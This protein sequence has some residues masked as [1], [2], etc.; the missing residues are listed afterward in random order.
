ML[1]R[2]LALFWLAISTMAGLVQAAEPLDPEKAYKFSARALD[3]KTI[4]ARWD[5][6][7][8]YYMYREKIAF[9]ADEAQLGTPDVAARVTSQ[10]K[11]KVIAPTTSVVITVSQCTVQKPPPSPYSPPGGGPPSATIRRWRKKC[12]SRSVC[13]SSDMLKKA[14]DGSA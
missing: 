14:R 2:L 8:D 6:T 11:P 5:I 12:S 9:R 1:I 13:F 3:E 10:R 7:R 4:E